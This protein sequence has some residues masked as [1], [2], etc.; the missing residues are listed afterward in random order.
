MA[1][2][3]TEAKPKISAAE[4]ERRREALRYAVS[5]NRIE[6]QFPNPATAPIFDAFV[7]G[8]ID[9]AEVRQR[10]HALHRHP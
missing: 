10:L 8:E 3:I 7:R 6:G 4:M 9:Q 1:T 2:G 5:H